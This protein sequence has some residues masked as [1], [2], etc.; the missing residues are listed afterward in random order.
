M[1][2]RGPVQGSVIVDP[3]TGLPI[4]TVTE[5][6]GSRRLAVDANISVD[7]VVVDTRPLKADTDTV[8]VGDPNNSNTVAVNADGSIDVNVVLDASTDNVAIKDPSSGNSLKVNADGSINVVSDVTPV[9]QTVKSFFNSITSVASG[10]TSSIITYTVPTGKT[11][12]LQRVSFSGSNIATYSVLLNSTEIDRQRVYFG[13][14]L[15]KNV[16]Y[17]SG[18]PLASEDVIEIEV[19]NFRPTSADFE[20]R[21]QI[22][23]VG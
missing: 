20:S 8:S 2:P 21:I 16:D 4:T 22:I 5:T 9:V 7:E 12:F 3:A 18:I 1:T 10:A 19:Y 14:D 6:D 15:T 13:G 17:S 11:A 23:E